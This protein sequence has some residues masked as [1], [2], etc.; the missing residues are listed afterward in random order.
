MQPCDECGYDNYYWANL[1]NCRNCDTRLKK[2]RKL[3]KKEQKKLN[4]Q[5][6]LVTCSL[7]FGMLLFW[8][9]LNK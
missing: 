6:L 1:K 8:W 4:F 2:Y 5:L 7:G 9:L 3:T